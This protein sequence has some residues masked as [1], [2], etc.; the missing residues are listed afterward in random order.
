[1]LKNALSCGCFAGLLPKKHTDSEVEDL[2]ARSDQKQ[3]PT[4]RHG[5]DEPFVLDPPVVVNSR[6]RWLGCPCRHRVEPKV[7][8]QQRKATPQWQDR[9]RAQRELTADLRAEW[10]VVQSSISAEELHLLQDFSDHVEQ[11]GLDRHLASTVEKPHARRAATLL[12][13]LRARNG[14]LQKAG[15]L[16]AE[17]LDWREDF[18]LDTRLKTL[19]AEI[20]SGDSARSRLIKKYGYVDYLGEDCEGNPVRL[21]R[22]SHA[23][24]GGLTRELGADDFL[25]YLLNEIET[26]LD[27]AQL[28]MLQS[29]RLF[30]GFVEIADLGD[31]A[32][33]AGWWTRSMG[34]IGPYS[35]FAPVFDKVYPERISVAFLLRTPSAFSVVWRLALPIIPEATRQKIRIKNKHCSTWK[36]E[37]ANFMSLE[38]LPSYLKDGLPV[39]S[40]SSGGVVP[41]DAYS[42]LKT[43]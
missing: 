34:A 8:P 36:H 29:R 10:E 41:K 5:H 18:Q 38:L 30:K 42:Q 15:A 23:D 28:R 19:R 11:L 6:R 43:L 32:V 12:R 33:V 20:A 4:Q 22:F 25:L 3:K 35:K 27:Q 1:M 26:A 39:R 16:L 24:P 17:A 31:D 14:D 40:I 13:F 9:S 7:V 21:Q 2:K 37:V